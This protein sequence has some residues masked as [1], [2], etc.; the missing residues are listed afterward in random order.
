M[1]VH[2]PFIDAG[3]DAPTA[4]RVCVFTG[5]GLLCVF[6]ALARVDAAGW[7]ERGR[8]AVMA[9]LCGAAFLPAWSILGDVRVLAVVCAL[10]TAVDAAR[11]QARACLALW[12]AGLTSLGASFVLKAV[13]DRPRPPGAFEAGASFPSTHSAM[14]A[15]VWLTLALLLTRQAPRLRL[16]TVTAAIVAA[17]FTAVAGVALGR[18]WPSDV[19]GGLALGAAVAGAAALGANARRGR[20]SPVAL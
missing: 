3:H 19:G 7:D 8:Q 13:F 5:A 12:G 9:A 10:V 6:M 16:P 11:R 1:R 14:A 20:P 4:A 17:L 2:Q 18:H 15:A